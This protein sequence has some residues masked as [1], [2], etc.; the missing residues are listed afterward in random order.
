FS[1]ARLAEWIDVDIFDRLVNYLVR[2]IQ[3]TG[4]YVSSTQS[5]KVQRYFIGIILSAAVIVLIASLLV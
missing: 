5:G 1:L 4:T 2:G 3:Y